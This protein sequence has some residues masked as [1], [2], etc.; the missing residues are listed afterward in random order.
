MKNIAIALLISIASGLIVAFI[1]DWIKNGSTQSMGAASGSTTQ[2]LAN[3]LGASPTPQTPA[4]GQ[5][6]WSY[7]FGTG[8]NQYNTN[9]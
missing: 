2:T 6:F 8:S 7:L 5:S 4:T 3:T 9:L 1:Y